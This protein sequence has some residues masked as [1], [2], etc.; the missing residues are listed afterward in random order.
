MRALSRSADSSRAGCRRRSARVATCAQGCQSTAAPRDWTLCT[1][2]KCSTFVRGHLVTVRLRSSLQLKKCKLAPRHYAKTISKFE[3]AKFTS[4]SFVDGRHARV[5]R[6]NAT[7]ARRPAAVHVPG[8]AYWSAPKVCVLRMPRRFSKATRRPVPRRDSSGR[9][10]RVIASCALTECVSGTSYHFCA[11]ICGV[12]HNETCF[13]W[14][15]VC[16]LNDLPF[17]LQPFADER[18]IQGRDRA[19]KTKARGRIPC[20]SEGARK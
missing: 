5:A 19:G 11:G 18:G 20:I 16:G 12:A 9:P 7:R 8:F 10:V 6:A 1:L 14:S 13:R 3:R 2:G 17:W 15:L 4:F